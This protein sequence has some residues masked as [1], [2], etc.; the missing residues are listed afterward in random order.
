MMTSEFVGARPVEPV[1]RQ[2]LPWVS[3]FFL[4]SDSSRWRTGV[5][6][7][8]EVVFEGLYEGIDL[9]YRLGPSG[10]KYDFVVAPGADPDIIEVR[11]NG[12]K[13]LD[14]RERVLVVSTA[15]GEI[16]DSGILAF[17]A[18]AP[19]EGVGCS[20][21]LRGPD[22]YG[23]HLSTFDDTR[24][25]VID[26]L[27]FSTFLGTHMDDYARDMD[28]DSE[29]NPIV[30][31]VTESNT[32]PTSV[33]AYDNDFDG[34]IDS[35]VTKL[36]ANGSA[37]LWSTFIGGGDSD[38]IEAMHL[39]KTEDIFIGGV[40]DSFD[41]PVSPSALQPNMGGGW[42]DAFVCKLSEDG[43]DLLY[44]TYIG[45]SGYE[46]VY[47]ITGDDNGC[48]Y[49]TGSTAVYDNDNSSTGFPTT[50]GAFQTNASGYDDGFVCKLNPTG[51]YLVY[52]T[53]LGADESDEIYSIAIDNQRCAYVCGYTN[54]P[55]FPN[56]TG[57]LRTTLE[58]R[59]DA[60]VTVL[61]ADGSD[62][63]YSTFLGGNAN[64]Y[65]AV[66]LLDYEGNPIV[67]GTTD[68]ADFPVTNG[69][70]Q[71]KLK[72]NDDTFVAKLSSDLSSMI[73]ATYIGGAE[74]DEPYN[75]D[76]DMNGN[77]VIIGDTSSSDFPTTA[78]AAQTKIGGEVDLFVTKL[79]TN[80]SKLI[81]STFLG[82]AN[83]DYSYGVGT[84]GEWFVYACG[85]SN[86]AGYPVTT[87]A[88]Q[89]ILK[90]QDDAIVTKLTMD[91]I[92]PTAVAGDDVFIDQHQTVMFN[93][94]ASWDNLGIVNFTWT[95]KYNASDVT[96]Y[97]T[98]PS[99]V[100][101]TVGWYVV[102]LTV[103][104][105]SGHKG[106]DD[107]N[108]TV[109]DITPPL[110]DAGINR[111]IRQYETVTFDGSASSDN[112]AV[113][114]W[115]WNFTYRGG[116]VHLF[117]PNPT[118]TFDQA[119]EFV[120]NLTVRDSVGLNA[121]DVLRVR[122]HDITPPEAVAGED[123][124]VDQH[125]T[126]QFDGALSS[127]NTG[128]TNWTWSFVH[129][130]VPVSLYGPSPTFLFEYA[131]IYTVVLRVKDAEGN[132]DIDDLKV[133]VLD[134]T[135]PV[136]NAGSDK[137]INQGQTVKFDGKG[138]TDNVGIVSYEWTFTYDT[139]PITRSGPSPDFTFG[140]AGS[141]EIALTVTDAM[142]NEGADVIVITVLDITAPVADAGP[143]ITT[144]QHEEVNFDGSGSTDNVGVVSCTWRFYHAGEDHLLTGFTSTF[145]FEEVGV[146]NV[147]M[148]VLDAEGNSQVDFMEVTV[149]DIT[150]PVAVAGED[151]TVDQYLSADFDGSGS[152]D[153]VG[154]EQWQWS[155]EYDGHPVV[156]VGRVQTFEFDFPGVYEVT[157]T[158]TDLAGN[159][160]SS[161]LT[162]TVKDT[163]RPYARAQGDL[164]VEAGGRVT[165]DAS[166]SSDNVGIVRWVWTFKEG[167]KT[168]ELEGETVGH[169][170]D[171]AGEYD[172]TLTVY[173]DDGNMA[174]QTFTV[175]VEG[176]SWLP[177]V[178]VVAVVA[179]VVIMAIV[180]LRRRSA[181]GG[182]L[183]DE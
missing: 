12:H 155:F 111:V 92:A 44:S 139:V 3:N 14:I 35:F 114:N 51:S 115:T 83:D 135:D 122:V 46:W 149:R 64:D 180:M 56:T 82:G 41:F 105:V 130:G 42:V 62:V 148:T 30:C 90:G 53:Y 95:F 143:D 89:T 113:V 17:Y 104:D 25:L 18:D 168:V 73:C 72:G 39:S 31:G 84:Y 181:G 65:G 24:A 108:V 142:G 54:S 120:V 145:T 58:G 170:F 128:I 183:E 22:T 1:G 109:R 63:N 102:T 8:Q 99:F 9:V 127:D 147:T 48:A 141:Y 47:S 140:L 119:G 137:V 96:L 179:V 50:L 55:G 32:F 175:T 86:S 2:A 110:A 57:A 4:G 66:I 174:V 150:L 91:I 118:F 169:T 13:S 182:D 70:F 124:V 27:V 68:S 52:S 136:A 163:T 156:L 33:G 78:R 23:F 126:V 93:G 138:S 26:P 67:M 61:D 74:D 129:G 77:V 60:F 88:Y 117:G 81:Y 153:N 10:I 164:T 152:T 49:L 75:A 178:A 159:S 133:E 172:V 151:Q 69:A 28:V 121:T 59:E 79:N 134:T 94:T 19:G 80:Y 34:E 161:S 116:M 165:F 107:L 125:V 16:V 43:T 176:A 37:I 45:G 85:G 160:A 5:L 112:V 103:E 7:Y 11:V 20:F 131:G 177:W 76:L 38:S 167:G 146:Y 36:A 162:L 166:A 101:H 173:D 158:V 123:M 144:D 40:T 154:V 98:V 71:T 21:E 106:K 171:E 97:D 157:L 100:F 6:S 29:G 132:L 15:A 87:G